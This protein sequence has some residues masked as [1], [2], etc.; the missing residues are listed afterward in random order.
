MGGAGLGHSKI[1]SYGSLEMN[2]EVV[3]VL[4]VGY[5]SYFKRWVVRFKVRCNRCGGVNKHGE[6][7]EKYPDGLH[8]AGSRS[9]DRC[10]KDYEYSWKQ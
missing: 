1:N 10:G 5:D 2:A 6:G 4:K 9:C 3:S 8:L 7:F